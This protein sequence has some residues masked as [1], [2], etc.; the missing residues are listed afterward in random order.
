[1]IVRINEPIAP[2]KVLFGLIWVNLGPLNNFPKI[3]P[4][5]SDDMHPIKII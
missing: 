5:I 4:P 1:M 3:K 2:E